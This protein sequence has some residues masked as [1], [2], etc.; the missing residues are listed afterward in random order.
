MDQSFCKKKGYTYVIS[1]NWTQKR[2]GLNTKC[3][4]H[5]SSGL[6]DYTQMCHR[7]MLQNCRVPW[8]TFFT[9]KLAENFLL[10]Y[11]NNHRLQAIAV[12]NSSSISSS[13]K[14]LVFRLNYL[15]WIHLNVGGTIWEAYASMWG[16]GG[17]S[18]RRLLA[19]NGSWK[20]VGGKLWT[21]SSI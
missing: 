18:P 2:H 20:L 14:K 1:K 19:L 9:L 4:L 13:D 5:F 10:R 15:F 8:L 6:W 11:E 3:V 17:E 16:R 7:Q 21:Y 12:K